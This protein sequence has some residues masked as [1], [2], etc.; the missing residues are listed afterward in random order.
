M[1]KKELFEKAKNAIIEA[2]EEMAI[3]I[4]DLAKK[5]NLDMIELLQTGFGSGNTEIGNRFEQ[6]ALSLPELIYAAEVMKNVT[7]YVLKLLGMDS[8]ELDMTA[9][10]GTI[11]IATV[12]GDIHDIGKGIVASSLK[13]AG[14]DVIDIGSGVSV[15]TIV[16]EAIKHDVDIIATSALLTS[17]MTEQRKLE[18]YLAEKN[19]KARFI[20]MV[21]GA[22]CTPRWAKK[23]G[24]GGYSEDAYDAVKV[25]LELMKKKSEE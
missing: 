9:S 22:P 3:E 11:L 18:K 5:A 15:E 25:A 13:A 4:V 21:G 14:F 16:E 24:A 12:K 1:E 20:T 10:K 23:I 7:D 8:S 2:D 6:G 19:H 17:T